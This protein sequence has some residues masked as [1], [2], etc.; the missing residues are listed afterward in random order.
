M[1]KTVVYR[2]IRP[3]QAEES[4]TRSEQHLYGLKCAFNNS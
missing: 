1:N 2:L 4:S 3:N